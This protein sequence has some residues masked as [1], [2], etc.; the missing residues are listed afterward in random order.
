[1]RSGRMRCSRSITDERDAARRRAPGTRAAPTS[2]R[3]A[4]LSRRTAR[5]TARS[6]RPAGAMTRAARRAR[7]V[8]APVRVRGTRVITGSST[9]PTTSPSDGAADDERCARCVPRGRVARAAAARIA[10]SGASNPVHSSNASA[11]WCTSMPRP[12][13]QRTP[14]ARA[15]ASSGVSTGWYTVSTT[16][17]P[18]LRRS[19]VDRRRL[20]LHAH[21]GRVHDEAEPR[22]SHSS[23][24]VACTPTT[25]PAAASAASRRRAATVTS[26]PAWARARVMARAA[27]PAPSTRHVGHRARCRD[28]APSAG[29]PRRRSTTPSRRPC[30]PGTTTFTASSAAASGVSSSHARAAS[31]L[32]RHGDAET[33]QPERA[34]R[35]ERSGAVGHAGPGTRRTPSRGR[36]LRMPRCG[37]RASASGAIGSP[38]TP[39]RRVDPPSRRGLIRRSPRTDGCSPR[40]PRVSS[41]K[42]VTP[43]SPVT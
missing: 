42:R 13:A 29:T 4:R 6:P 36:R 11:A 20:A 35:L 17:W 38:M 31:C 28:R 19:G 8:R 33:G 32:V 16:N 24:R 39:A 34:H 18:G 2:R 15:A 12:L 25:R 3:T 40:A 7:P 41:A 23:S 22:G 1:M 5:R 27:P 37:S 30:S 9:H 43:S 26:A 21:R 14:R 10:S